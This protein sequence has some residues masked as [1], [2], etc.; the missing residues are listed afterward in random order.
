MRNFL[1]SSGH[2]ATSFQPRILTMVVLV[3]VS[4][5]S[6]SSQTVAIP[7][8]TEQAIEYHRIS[9]IAWGINEAAALLI[10]PMLFVI[11]G[12]GTRISAKTRKLGEYFTFILIAVVLFTVTTLISLPLERIR[13]NKLNETMND[14][15]APL[16]EWV[17]GQVLGS[18]PVIVVSIAA[19]L[20]VFWLIR[21][22]P[23]KWWL[24]AAGAGSLLFLA[25]LVGE[26]LTKSYKPL[27][28]SP[29]E[30]RIAELAGQAGIPRDR[31]A[32]EH[33]VPVDSCDNA[34]VS[35]LG[36][37]R[38]VLL[39]EVLFQTQPD[40]WT[41][42]TVAHEAKHFV[43]DDNLVGWVVMTFLLLVLFLLTDIVSR[44]ILRGFSGRL[45]FESI[46]Q[47]AALP[48]LILVLNGFYLAALPPVNVFRQHVESEADRFGLELTG[49]SEVFAEMVS[50]WT[51]ES[52]YRVPEPS[53]F[54]MLFRSSHPSDASRITFAN[55]FRPKSKSAEMPGRH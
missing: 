43:K 39:N 19:A 3:L 26:P 37:T 33:C 23:R 29:L 27:G 36:P 42:Q 54:F 34:H 12:L 52:T 5:L 6:V 47:A 4:A 14:A 24:W 48:L 38:I 7:A 2:K 41:V 18:L 44:A 16:T 11:L 17:L 10:L 45:G 9:N 22:S 28:Q 21:M 51:A 46:G 1:S 32:L 53:L 13:I 50:S 49:E 25:F 30:V 20:L 35:G 15:G 55:E 40:N 8:A 31:I